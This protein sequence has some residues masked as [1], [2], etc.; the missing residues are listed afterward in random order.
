[1]PDSR[2]CEA[3]AIRGCA[4]LDVGIFV[5]VTLLRSG[6]VPGRHAKTLT[7]TASKFVSILGLGIVA[8]DDRLFV[9]DAEFD[10]RR[11]LGLLQ[12]NTQEFTIAAETKVQF[13]QAVR[14]DDRFR[15]DEEQEQ[16]ASRKRLGEFL[17]PDT[18]RFDA[19]VISDV[20][21]LVLQ[22][23]NPRKYNWCVL[24]GVAHKDVGV[25]TLVSSKRSFHR[26]FRIQIDSSICTRQVHKSSD[27]STRCAA[28]NRQSVCGPDFGPFPPGQLR[29]VQPAIGTTPSASAHFVL[30]AMPRP[31]L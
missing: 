15:R 7:K 8:L 18:A 26:C 21:A 24:V 4:V 30:L 9:R 20:K 17:A 1:M 25:I 11:Q 12:V 16:A 2:P 22:A 28:A 3:D 10:R 29:V 5:H 14:R 23:R 31:S 27:P 13:L 6:A 19:L